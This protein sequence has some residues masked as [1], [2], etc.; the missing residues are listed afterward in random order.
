[1]VSSR[2]AEILSTSRMESDAMISG[3]IAMSVFPAVSSSIKLGGLPVT[4]TVISECI[5]FGGGSEAS[6]C[7]LK[8]E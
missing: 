8:R 1:M 6:S 7:P 5:T 3:V 4:N 2:T